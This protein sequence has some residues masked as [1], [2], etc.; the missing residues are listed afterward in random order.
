MLVALPLM[1]NLG[2]EPVELLVRHTVGLHRKPIGTPSEISWRIGLVAERFPQGISSTRLGMRVEVVGAVQVSDA[3]HF[4]HV[5][6][7]EQSNDLGIRGM[8]FLQASQ[9]R[10]RG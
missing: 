6:A 8:Q 2:D 10:R 5:V 7:G 1:Q 3:R 9:R 4:G